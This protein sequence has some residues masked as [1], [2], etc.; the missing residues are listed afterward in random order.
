VSIA[1]PVSFRK[2]PAESNPGTRR[3]QPGCDV[4]SRHIPGFQFS[5]NRRKGQRNSMYKPIRE[6][7]R[8]QI[9][10]VFIVRAAPAERDLMRVQLEK[11]SL[12][13]L[14]QAYQVLQAQTQLQR[15]DEELT[16]IAVEIEADRIWHQETM[17]LACEPQRKAEEKAQLGKDRQTFAKAAKT[18]RTFRVTEANFNVCRSTLGG[19][20]SIYDI[21]KMLEANGA[22]LSGPTQQELD[23][24]ARQDVED[25]NQR[26]LNSDLPTLR[27]LAREA[28]AKG[29]APVA[30]DETQRVRQAEKADGEMKYPSL[31]DEFRD[32]DGP[33]EVL[34][35]AFVKKCSKET[36]RRLIK[37][38]G[39][40]QI[41]DL[42]QN[43]VAGSI[44]E[45]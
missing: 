19:G 30:P 13:E 28:G 37:Q 26:L 29:P 27:R 44:W 7:S 36:L 2:I 33:E 32:G 1:L 6:R 10:E 41:D 8:E 14:E 21:Q 39:S 20:F 22:V 31:P 18:L 42:L 11:M 3:E 15:A 12:A 23:E 25:H 17:R 40:N 45:V 34:N 35:A 24:W 4:S 16:R 5:I 43:R 9:I 38:Y